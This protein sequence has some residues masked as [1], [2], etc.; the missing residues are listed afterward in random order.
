M[1]V[2]MDYRRKKPAKRTEKIKPAA[3]P[4]GNM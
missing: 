2:G 1:K 4:T 3:E